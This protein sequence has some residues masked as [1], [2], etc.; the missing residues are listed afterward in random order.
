MGGLPY[1]AIGNSE[2]I[3]DG[4]P[5]EVLEFVREKRT[6]AGWCDHGERFGECC[7]YPE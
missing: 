3:P 6:Q 1:I 2:P 4:L 7:E 5:D